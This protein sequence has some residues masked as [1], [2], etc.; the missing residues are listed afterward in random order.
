MALNIPNVGTNLEA[1]MK[2]MDAGG[3]LFS[4]IMQPTLDREH[5]KQ[6]AEQ[7]KQQ[8]ALRQAQFARSGQNSDINRKILEQQLMHLKNAND[9]MYEMN[10][11]KALENFIKGGGNSMG[12]QQ[13]AQQLPVPTQEMGEGMGMFTPE[14][15]QQAQ[16]GQQGSPPTGGIDL[17]LLKSHPMLRGWAKKHLHFDPLAQVPQT[18]EEKQAASLDLFNKKENIK[19]ANKTGSGETLTAPIKTKYQNVIGGVTSARPIL[20]KLISETKKGNIPG[21]MF[22]SIFK[23]DAQASYKGEIST[24]LDGIRNAYTIPNTDSGTAKA[25]DKVLRKGGESDANYANRLQSILNQLDAREKDARTK[26]N[27]GNITAGTVHLVGPNGED[28][29]VPESEVNAIL[30]ENPGVR[31]G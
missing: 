2:G 1:L 15:M 3:S 25:E 23:R 14:G 7:F 31:R 12:G 29:D 21:Q 18:P 6:A 28:Y 9:P 10:Q 22:G 27:A 30:Q 4:R 20:E 17:E 11:Y 26:L 5:Q 16:Q 19:L 8:M 24:L 13:G